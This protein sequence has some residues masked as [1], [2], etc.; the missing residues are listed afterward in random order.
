MFH[1]KNLYNLFFDSF[2]NSA[3]EFLAL[4][5]FLGIEPIKKLSEMPFDSR[6]IYGLFKENKRRTL[7][8][9][10]TSQSSEKKKIYYPEIAC[11]SKCYLWL[12][13]GVP[14]KGFIGS[15][16]FSANGLQN[17]YRESLLEVDQKQ[18][19]L[20]KGYIDVILSS[21]VLCTEVEIEEREPDGEEYDKEKCTMV[22]YDPRSGEVQEKHGLNWGQAFFN[23]S[24]VNPNDSCIPIRTK[25]IR[26]YP[27]LFKPIKPNPE[28]ER[29]SLNEVIEII[30][31]DGYS[32]KGRLEGS[33]PINGDRYPKQIASF[34]SKEEMG[35]Y[36]RS[37][38]GVGSGE[39]ITRD[40]LT[41]Y[42]RDTIDLSLIE[43]G[44]YLIDFSV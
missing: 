37:R 34:P 42:G 24:H 30:F 25:H 14:I 15:A 41:E 18:L 20:I 16:N 31:D 43:E 33:Q 22:L 27:N 23:G 35:T 5:G 9:Q 1:Y 2:P 11:H 29:G 36:F 38:I 13:E 39:R 6:V 7:H 10:L 21:S 28:R 32:M 17:D 3:D 19:F 4:S 12:K 8:D 40:K 44:V 26:K